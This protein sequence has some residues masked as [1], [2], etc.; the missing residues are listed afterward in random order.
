MEF[1]GRRAAFFADGSEYLAGFRK[2]GITVLQAWELRKSM[3]DRTGLLQAY[4]L[5]EFNLFIIVHL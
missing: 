1:N 3:P 4:A 5:T 2:F